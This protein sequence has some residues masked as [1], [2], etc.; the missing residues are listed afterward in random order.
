V[1][2]TTGA[3]LPNSDASDDDNINLQETTV[4]SDRYYAWHGSETQDPLSSHLQRSTSPAA[5]GAP[6]PTRARSSNSSRLPQAMAL[7]GAVL[8]PAQQM[9]SIQ[10]IARAPPRPG[11]EVIIS[12]CTAIAVASTLHA[13]VPHH[14]QHTLK[15][16][17]RDHD[18]SPGHIE[19]EQVVP[20][21]MPAKAWVK[22][23]AGMCKVP[24]PPAHAPQQFLS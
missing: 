22:L 12:F 17:E 9:R 21:C 5:Q 4:L 3:W 15:R 16:L 7:S 24:V 23:L 1:H 2:E 10:Y 6:V 13:Q 14:E 18:R 11:L 19:G 20:A 8:V